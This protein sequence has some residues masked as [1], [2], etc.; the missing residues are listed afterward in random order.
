[1]FDQN[2]DEIYES[3]PN[4]YDNEAKEFCIDYGI[5]KRQYDNKGRPKLRFELEGIR[6]YIITTHSEKLDTLSQRSNKKICKRSYTSFMW[7][8]CALLGI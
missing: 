6:N 3:E 7:S 5:L 4:N 1:M 2:C 8:R